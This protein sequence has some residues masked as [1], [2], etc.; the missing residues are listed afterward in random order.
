MQ[1]CD[2]LGP[3]C[4]QDSVMEFSF[5]LRARTDL[6]ETADVTPICNSVSNVTADSVIVTSHTLM[7]QLLTSRSER[8]SQ[9][10]YVCFWEVP[11][12]RLRDVR[13][14]SLQWNVFASVC[15]AT[16]VR[17]HGEPKKLS[18]NYV[19]CVRR[20]QSLLRCFVKRNSFAHKHVFSPHIKW[21]FSAHLVQFGTFEAM[22]Q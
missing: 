12:S 10:V 5:L 17:I 13:V 8:L 15:V 20:F 16:Y 22:N 11:T 4:D 21:L 9:V 1:V 18:R 19:R 6:P 2:Q 14:M 3:V 7:S